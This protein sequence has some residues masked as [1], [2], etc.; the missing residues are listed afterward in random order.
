MREVFGS[1]ARNRAGARIL[2]SSLILPGPMRGGGVAGWI[3]RRPTWARI[4]NWFA[5][6][7][8]IG[9]GIRLALTDRR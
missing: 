6:F 9:L 5:G 3:A 1:R 2:S 8:L 7:M 4:Q